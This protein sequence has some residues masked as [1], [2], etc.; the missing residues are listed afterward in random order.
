M[1]KTLVN[2]TQ[3]AL[4]AEIETVLDNYPYHPYQ[5]AF[6]NPDLRQ[7][8]I[9][10]VLSHIPCTYTISEENP[11]VLLTYQFRNCRLEPNIQLENFI[12]QGICSVLQEKTDWVNSHVPQPFHCGVEPSHWFG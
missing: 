5:Q 7:E 6:A 12:H 11:S 2:L 9:A 3:Q 1:V 4:V 8:L 10:Y